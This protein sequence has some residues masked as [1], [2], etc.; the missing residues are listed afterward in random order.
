M[1]SRPDSMLD[2]CF[3]RHVMSWLSVYLSDLNEIIVANESVD[4]AQA[5]ADFEEDDGRLNA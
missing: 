3:A 1:Q 4:L 5:S 2:S